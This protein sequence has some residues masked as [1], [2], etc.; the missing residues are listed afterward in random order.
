M[1]NK[2]KKGPKTKTSLTQEFLFVNCFSLSHKLRSTMQIQLFKP[3]F[4]MKREIKKVL[5]TFKNLKK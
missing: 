1:Q 5:V 3:Y 2:F 4:C